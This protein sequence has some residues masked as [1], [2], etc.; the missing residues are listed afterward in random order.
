MIEKHNPTIT[1]DFLYF[2]S[3]KNN[4]KDVLRVKEIAEKYNVT[5][6]ITPEKVFEVVKEELTFELIEFFSELTPPSTKENLVFLLDAINSIIILKY[7]NDE[8]K[9]KLSKIALKLIS[10]F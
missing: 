6:R 1:E 7:T 4:E 2:N 9:I 3:L 10:E 8:S 5:H